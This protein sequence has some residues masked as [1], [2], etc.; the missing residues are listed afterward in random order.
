MSTV[1]LNVKKFLQEGN[2]AHEYQPFKNMLLEDGSIEDFNTDELKLDLNNPLNIE[3]QPSYD[4]TVNLIINDDKNPPRIINSRF[5]KLE[6]NRYKIINRNQIQQTNLYQVGKIDQQTR[7]FRNINKI[8]KIDLVD[9]KAFGQLKGGNYTFYIKFADNDYNKTDVVAESGVVSVFKGTWTDVSSISGTLQDERTDKA[10]TLSISNIDTSFA[11]IYIY[12][13]RQYSDINGTIMEEAGMFKEPYPIKNNSTYITLNG[14]EEIEKINSEELN[15]RYNLVT[16]VKTQAQVQNM[17]FFGNVEGINLDLK[18]LQNI[19]Y[20]IDVKLK[21]NDSGIG[22]VNEVYKQPAQYDLSQCEY[23]NPNHIYYNLGYWPDEIYRLGIVYIMNDDS[24]SPVFN[25]RGRNFERTDRNNIDWG[26]NGDGIKIATADAYD[27]QVDD[28]NVQYLSKDAITKYKDN[29][30][31]YKYETLN[32]EY[33]DNGKGTGR[34]FPSGK[35]EMNWIPNNDY[36]ENSQYLDNTFGVFKNPKMDTSTQI[37]NYTD[38]KIKPWYYE[39][40][41]SKDIIDDL[42]KLGVKGYFIV[43]QKRIMTTLCQGL[44]GAIDIVSYIPMLTLDGNEGTWFTESFL[45]NSRLLVNDF[46]THKVTTKYK[47]SSCIYTLDPIVTPALQ[48]IFDGSQFIINYVTSNG[49]LNEAS[50]NKRHFYLGPNKATD[51]ITIKGSCLFIDEDVPIKFMNNFGFST[52]AGTQ[53]EA[54][55]FSFF[56]KKDYSGNNRNLLRGI[57]SAYLG[58]DVNI[59]GN[60]I[61]N[62]KVGNYS[63]LFLK[64]Y[65]NIRGKDNSEFFAITERFAIDDSYQLKED[66]DKKAYYASQNKTFDVYRGDCYASNVTMRL[67]RNFIDSEVPINDIIVDSDTWSKNY[68]GYMG[69]TKSEDWTNIN[70]ADL[71]TVPLGMWLTF[72]CLSNY[73]LNLRSEDRQNTDEMALMGNP[74]SFYP[75]SSVS[76]AVSYKIS[77]SAIQNSGYNTTVGKKRNLIAPNVPY[78]N[79]LYDNRIM[80]SNVQVDDDFRNAYRIFQGLSYEDIDRQ[81][82]AIVKLIPWGANLLCVFEHGIG[83]VP[84]NE[85]ALMQTTT[86]QNIHLYGSDVIQRQIS[87]ISPDFGSIW[88]ESI[89]RTPLGV[90]G[91]DTYAK[92]IWRY[93]DSKGLETISDMKI[94]RFL[95]DHIKL[96]E[97]DK[98]PIIGLRNVKTHYNNYKGDVM[99]TFYNFSQGEEWNF[100]FNERM[101]KWVTRYSWTPLYSENINNIFYSLDKK[102]VEVLSH[103]YNNKHTTSGL[104]TSENKW[105]AVKNN[106]KALERNNIFKSDLIL[107]GYSL[108]TDCE[109]NI[110]N[111]ET[112]CLDKNGVEHKINIPIKKTYFGDNIKIIHTIDNN[113]Y[114]NQ[115]ILNEK[116]I[117]STYNSIIEELGIDTD[118]KTPLYYLIDVQSEPKVTIENKT[119]NLKPFKTRIG[120]I[121]DPINEKEKEQRDKL[122]V[123]GFYVHGRAGIFDEMSY[124]SPNDVNRILP[125]KWYDK[126]EP[127]EFEFVVNGDEIGMHKIFD[128]LV[129]IS[130]NVEPESFEFSIIGDVYSDI[131]RFKTKEEI[132]K[133]NDKSFFKNTTVEWDPILNHYVLITNQ[134]TK[135]FNNPNYGRRLGNITYKEDSWY[136]NIEPIKFNTSL[137]KNRTK[138]GE[139]RI[140]DKYIKIRVRYKGDKLAIITA[141]KSL[142]RLSFS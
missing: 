109:I 85:K 83:I 125:T 38:K 111:V 115:L 132:Y 81:Y 108:A 82:G 16:N 48:S 137:N 40:S 142:Y 35:Y 2:L 98:Y 130:N 22:W 67:N 112:S 3:C 114:T 117:K 77:E 73:N 101:D 9:L 113:E 129:I 51:Q 93:T 118:Y 5:T 12:Y 11:S 126:Q 44:S 135:N 76:T 14:Y 13:V 63:E 123:N 92:K 107:K 141:L 64:D 46:T 21:Q 8:P 131:Y 127:F 54:K 110:I 69:E 28:N 17:L 102:R 70:K 119:N 128:N 99:F 42:K 24:L 97:L 66:L 80:F 134:K 124:D 136:T 53:E 139:T 49:T 68:K 88:Q 84:I 94:Q 61:V 79:D 20:F 90:Y 43:R 57:W 37:I 33:D 65:F 27:W 31:V 87:L 120:I 62:I 18:T 133:E 56:S 26:L 89:I 29:I 45:T 116:L 32:Q 41:I 95:N 34:Y 100:C 50:D 6:D 122:L 91:V 55:Q 25:L 72:K 23:Y 106:S 86:G 121:V 10:I 36:I 19:S 59:P 58:T 4:G 78:I 104:N 138:Y 96:D 52:R 74:R 103:I 60:T 140:R 105:I 47:Q 30:N 7:L 15:I 75:L 39:F 71:N 1:N